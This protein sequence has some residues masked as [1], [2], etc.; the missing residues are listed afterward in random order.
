VS[1]AGEGA[2]GAAAA[3]SAIIIDSTIVLRRHLRS[4]H[5]MALAALELGDW[6]EAQRLAEESQGAAMRAMAGVAGVTSIDSDAAIARLVEEW[7]ARLVAVRNEAV[8]LWEAS[9]GGERVRL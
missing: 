7:R 4:Q 1:A 8:L 2:T 5:A 6:R 9:D 3:D